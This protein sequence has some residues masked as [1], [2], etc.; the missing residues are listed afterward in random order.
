MSDQTVLRE[1]SAPAVPPAAA[2]EAP[3]SHGIRPS[4]RSLV[5]GAVLFLVAAVGL[6]FYVPGFWQVSTDDAYVN[7]HVVSIV[8]KVA[9]MF[10][11]CMSTTIPKLRAMTCSSSSIQGTSRLP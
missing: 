6:Y 7:A 3:S 8:P 5:T 1:T 11:S 2:G 10:R 4:R 9:A